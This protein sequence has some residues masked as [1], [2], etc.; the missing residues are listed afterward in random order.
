MLPYDPQWND[1]SDYV[2]HFAKPYNDRTAYDNMISI[3]AGNRLCAMNPFGIARGRAPNPV[4]QNAV[5]LS[6]TPLHLLERLSERRGGYGIGFTKE[7]MLQR[8]GGPIWYVE[9]QSAREIALQEMIQQALASPNPLENPI[10][11]VTP[12]IDLAGEHRGRQHR[13]EWER[14]WRIVGDLPFTVDDVAFL[15]IPEELHNRAR[16]FFEN[17]IYENIGPGYLCPYIDIGWDQ[18]R[19]MQTLGNH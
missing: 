18:D 4:T 5:C 2:V 8:G 9:R 15:I 14:E 17:A 1:M 3:L 16:S 19:I 11:S 6:E 10:W 7:F 13:Y 12:F